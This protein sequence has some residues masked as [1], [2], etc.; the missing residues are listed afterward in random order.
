MTYG[1]GITE[2]EV[3]KKPSRMFP[4]GLVV[5][6]VGS[7]GDFRIIRQEG[8]NLPGPLPHWNTRGEA[9]WP[10]VHVPYSPFG[11]RFWA[12][13][14]LDTAIQIQDAV[15]RTDSLIE[16]AMSRTA[17]PIWLEPKGA[18]VKKFT[19]EPGI[20][21]KYTPV[22]LGTGSSK[23]ERIEGSTIPAYVLNSREMKV[24]AF[25]DQ[26]GTTDP[27]KG[28]KP[29][30]VEAFSAMQLLVERSQTRFTIPLEERG[31]G[32]QRW[33]M[34]S[35]ELERLYGPD[36]RKYA[37]MG[38]NGA[39]TFEAFKHA[40]ISGDI[41]L[42]IEDGSQQ[43]KTSLGKR[44]S[45]QQLDQMQLIP[46][47]DP[48][49]VYEILRTMGSTNLLPRLDVGIKSALR[50]QDQ[51]ERWVSGP[52]S[53]Q[54]PVDPMAMELATQTGA[55]PPT[56]Y[57]EP[58]PFA[59]EKWHDHLIH[60]AQHKKWANSDMAVRIFTARPDLKIVWAQHIS[61]HEMGLAGDVMF[62]TMI[63]G[64]GMPAPGGAPGG[65][66][67]MTNSNRESGN[68]SDV[69]SGAGEGAQGRGPE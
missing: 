56:Q 38:P 46:K 5:R 31:R 63:A 28:G 41:E 53:Q 39:W 29:P 15:N 57:L 13:S 9:I 4:Q 12:R 7:G 22:L 30:G 6:A 18:E 37:V 49:V 17:N 61:E 10:W 27:F 3:W 48:D 62:E 68:P 67:S 14:P 50:E 25:N 19:G 43:P 59:V 33:A 32:R 54:A 2:Y 40:N 11:G 8:E 1:E 65:G 45:I 47:E 23:P 55:M 60:I 42:L 16:L 44:A 35:L 36:E 58:L 69:P 26:L 66:Q 51:F 64:G 20:V 24:K 34:V 52:G 21:V